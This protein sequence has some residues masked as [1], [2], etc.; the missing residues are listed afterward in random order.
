MKLK[1]LLNSLNL[2]NAC[3]IDGISS[4]SRRTL[5]RITCL[6]NRRFRLSVF[7]RL[8]KNAKLITL[9]K[10]N[11]YPKNSSEFSPIILSTTGKLLKR[12]IL[13]IIQRH[14][15]TTN[16]LHAIQCI[17]HAR[18]ITTVQCMLLTDHVTFSFN[19]NMS[20]AAVFLDIERLLTY[21][22]PILCKLLKLEFRFYLI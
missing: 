4:T 20:T 1:K 15:V 8:W 10:P 5:F 9:P 16:T 2:I 18:H 14:I 13:K 11:K 7:L 19:T 12:C 21:V 17:C 22:A 6:F 3:G